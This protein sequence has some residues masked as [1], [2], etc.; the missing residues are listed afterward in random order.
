MNKNVL[1]ICREVDRCTE[2]EVNESL[3]TPRN[4]KVEPS[5]KHSL[6]ME[7]LTLKPR[8]PVEDVIECWDDDDDLQGVED[9]Q[10]RNVSSNTAASN[11]F[12]NQRDSISSRMSTRSNSFAGGDEDWQL[13]IPTDDEAS[14]TN[15]IASANSAGIPIPTSV[16]SSALRGGTIK[17]LG[18]R[19]LKKV[20]G[21]DWEN[22]L[23]LPKAHEE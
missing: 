4:N 22:D 14:T 16:P 13:L 6:T 12:S 19:R 20:I 11:Q 8:K 21:D 1:P 10:L 7:P 15:A 23:D 18:G 5:Q 3:T 17:R 2:P 9:L